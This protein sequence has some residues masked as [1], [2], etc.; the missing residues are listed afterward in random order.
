MRLAASTWK[1]SH[2][3][4]KN[5][6]MW[7]LR[8]FKIIFVTCL[9]PQC[10]N[11]RAY[12]SAQGCV[13]ACGTWKIWSRS[14]TQPKTFLS[15]SKAA[16]ECYFRI[17]GRKTNKRGKK[18]KKTIKNEK[19]PIKIVKMPLQQEV[20]AHLFRN[21]LL[22]FA[23]AEGRRKSRWYVESFWQQTLASWC[24]CGSQVQ[25]KPAEGCPAGPL[26]WRCGVLKG[27]S[28]LFWCSKA[29]RCFGDLTERCK[30]PPQQVGLQ[31]RQ[32][33]P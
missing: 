25:G 21:A 7:D 11:L 18:W 32:H 6:A 13:A 29:R 2:L 10:P 15:Y 27:H 33:Y 17:S 5:M 4:N 28:K 22:D 20:P 9:R 24:C 16:S 14:Y 1:C 12:E 31:I 23:S 8:P 3:D 30:H 26:R 19:K